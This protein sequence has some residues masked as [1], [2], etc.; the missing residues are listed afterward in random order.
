MPGRASLA[1]DRWHVMQH[2]VR[3]TAHIVQLIRLL[4]HTPPP[5][6]LVFFNAR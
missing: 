6:D 1:R 5:L 2:E 3:H 4:G